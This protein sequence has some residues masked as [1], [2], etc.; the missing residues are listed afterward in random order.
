MYLCHRMR[1]G[2]HHLQVT[3]ETEAEKGSQHPQRHMTGKWRGRVCP[4]WA[5]VQPLGLGCRENLRETL[6]LTQLLLLFY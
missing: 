6:N 1:Q 4:T 2:Y 5:G 3:D